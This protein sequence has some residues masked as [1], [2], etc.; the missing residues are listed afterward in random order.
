MVKEILNAGEE[1]A[2]L[3]P[4]DGDTD[5]LIRPVEMDLGMILEKGHLLFSC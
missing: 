1:R 5:N 3:N 4:N 2:P